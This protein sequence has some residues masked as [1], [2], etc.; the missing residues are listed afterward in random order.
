MHSV[1]VAIQNATGL[2]AKHCTMH[3]LGT[4]FQVD[5]DASCLPQSVGVL[6]LVLQSAVPVV[7]RQIWQNINV[8]KYIVLLT[9]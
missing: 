2:I 6:A 1:V 3:G 9:N 7:F 8:G 4:S 5:L